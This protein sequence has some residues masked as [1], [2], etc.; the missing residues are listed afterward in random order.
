V[1]DIDGD[2]S[3]LMNLQEMAMARSENIA[4]KALVLNNQHLGMVMQLEDRFYQRNRAHTYL[5][6]PESP[7]HLYPDYV[8]IAS[9][10]GI[11]SERVL[12][13]KDLRAAMERM[14]KAD[15]PYLLEVVVPS[16]EHVLPFIPAG[17]AV[18]DMMM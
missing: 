17:R 2:G 10:F 1:I 18:A 5:G 15:E 8:A 4:V 13:M 3:F 16:S 11:K 9:G 7:T 12:F 14:L 6:R